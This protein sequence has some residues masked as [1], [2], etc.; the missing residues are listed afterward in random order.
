MNGHLRFRGICHSGLIWLQV[1]Q[2]TTSNARHTFLCD[3]QLPA[4][5]EVQLHQVNHCRKMNKMRFLSF[6][7]GWMIRQSCSLSLSHMKKCSI[8]GL[9]D[10]YSVKWLKKQLQEQYKEHQEKQTLYDLR[11]WQMKS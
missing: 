5:K 8:N 6:L 11:I 1:M 10:T 7:T 2:S 9:S 4:L 3:K